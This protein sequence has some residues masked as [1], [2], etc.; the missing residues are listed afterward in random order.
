MD[1]H[2]TYARR[3]TAI[4]LAKAMGGDW[5]TALAG[6]VAGLPKEEKT[7]LEKWLSS[8]QR[9]NTKLLEEHLGKVREAA[10]DLLRAPVEKGHEIAAGLALADQLGRMAVAVRD[11]MAGT[12]S[13]TNDDL[14]TKAWEILAGDED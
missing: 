3:L 9:Q 2:N 13:V 10:K 5:T 7:D 12:E 14:L 4:E 1:N 6:F 11:F 8:R